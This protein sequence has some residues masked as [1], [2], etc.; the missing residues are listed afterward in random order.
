MPNGDG[1]GLEVRRLSLR[2]G[3]EKRERVS[4]WIWETGL[5]SA[6]SSGDTGINIFFNLFL[7]GVGN[8]TASIPAAGR[9]VQVKV[10]ARAAPAC[11]HQPSAR[12]FHPKPQ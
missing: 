5:L 6:Q 12:D 8:L 7:G 9:Q 11:F 2:D 10:G 3:L 4:I 1:P